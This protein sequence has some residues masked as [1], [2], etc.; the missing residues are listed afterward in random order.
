VKKKDKALTATFRARGKGRL[1][2]VFNAIGF[3]CPNYP[4]LTQSERRRGKLLQNCLQMLQSRR[5]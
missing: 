5:K 1:N 2:Y 4:W 3:F